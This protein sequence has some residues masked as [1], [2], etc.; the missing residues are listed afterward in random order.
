MVTLPFVPNTHNVFNSGNLQLT[1][2][3]DP[4]VSLPDGLWTFKYSVFP[5]NQ[6]FVEKSFFRIDNLQEN[7]D[8]AFLTLDM[9]ECDLAVKEQHKLELD[10]IYFMIQGAI[11]AGN[12][13]MTDVA[14]RLYLTAAKALNKF[15]KCSC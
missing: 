8:R 7:F 10:S 11:A 1:G 13:C 4:L 14:N 15:V 12:N 5:N 9:M 6:Y 2:P 3:S